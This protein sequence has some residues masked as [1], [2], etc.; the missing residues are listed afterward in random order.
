MRNN[1]QK[2]VLKVGDEVICVKHPIHRFVGCKLTVVEFSANGY[3]LTKNS[4]G[5]F[6]QF[7]PE[8]LALVQEAEKLPETEKFSEATRKL[9]SVPLSE[10]SPFSSEPTEISWTLENIT[11]K[12]TLQLIQEFTKANPKTSVYFV[13]E[14]FVVFY[15]GMQYTANDEDSLVKIMEAVTLL[16]SC[17]V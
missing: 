12:S 13:G 8:E 1:M 7:L 4:T 10:S 6:G 9:F 5:M 3:I 14:V 2:A 11:P 15:E 17:S 16:E